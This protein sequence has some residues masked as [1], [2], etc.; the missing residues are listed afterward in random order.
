[1]TRREPSWDELR[2]F[3]E[4]M[5]DGSLSGAAR[6]L[7]VAQ[8]TVGRHI[9]ALERALGVALFARSPR[10]LAPTDAA[11]HLMPHVEAMAS[12]SAALERA[13]AGEISANSGVVRITASEIVGCEV[14]P[15]MIASFRAK[16]PGVAIELAITNR[17]EDLS[18]RDADIAVRMVRPAQHALVARRIGETRVGLFAH[19]EYLARFGTPTSLEELAGHRLIGY[20]RDD[21]AFR[22]AGAFGQRLT[23][24]DF[25]FRCDSDPARLAAVRAGVGIGGAQ[26]NV[27]RRSP[28]LVRLLREEVAIPL[29]VWLVM[30]E[31]LK[32]TPRVRA[33]FEHLAA[34]LADFVAGR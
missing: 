10:G 34:G 13:A 5:R 12:A 17:N 24:E 33:L 9:D 15:P 32:S 4:V 18:R 19:R 8:P 11:T 26:E 31:D 2:T 28:E 29:D 7:G 23:R 27:A 30:H 22:A 16:N 21:S 25:G 6:R 20:D 14:L 1:M 3:R